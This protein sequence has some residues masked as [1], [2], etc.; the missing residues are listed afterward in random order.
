[1]TWRERYEAYLETLT[2]EQLGAECER[3]IALD[4]RSRQ[5]QGE[6]ASDLAWFEA[7]RRGRSDLWLAARDRARAERAEAARGSGR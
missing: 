5:Q 6:S 4:L 1:M 2:D 3:Q 7:C